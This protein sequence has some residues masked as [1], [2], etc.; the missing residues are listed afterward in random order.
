[1]GGCGVFWG[2]IGVRMFLVMRVRGF[3]LLST[4]GVLLVCFVV[5][6]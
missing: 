1:M 4:V 5:C 3:V 6:V 2:C